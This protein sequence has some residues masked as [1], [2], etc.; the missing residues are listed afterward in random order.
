MEFLIK[1]GKQNQAKE[2][3]QTKNKVK[4]KE[5]KDSPSEDILRLPWKSLMACTAYVSLLG[6]PRARYEAAQQQ[7]FL[8]KKLRLSNQ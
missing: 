4:R 2:T 1:R 6:T 8:N 7:V 3:K 5:V